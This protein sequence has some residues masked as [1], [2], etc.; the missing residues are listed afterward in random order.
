MHWVE[1]KQQRKLSFLEG[2]EIAPDGSGAT[3]FLDGKLSHSGA[4][5]LGLDGPQNTPLPG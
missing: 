1:L 3:V 2:S 5:L 4:V